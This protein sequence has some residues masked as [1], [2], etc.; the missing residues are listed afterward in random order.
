M[1]HLV[2]AGSKPA[3]NPAITAALRAAEG[4]G[5]YMYPINLPILS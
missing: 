4:G 3:P 5:P 1:Y 2:G